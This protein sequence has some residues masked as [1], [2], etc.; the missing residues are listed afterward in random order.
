MTHEA[1]P[2][3]GPGAD[4]IAAS[5]RITSV[6]LLGLLSTGL[7]LWA[8][9][10]FRRT[11]ATDLAAFDRLGYGRRFAR[12]HQLNWACRAGSEICT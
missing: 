8:R 5:I 7:L 10:R 2:G 1:E 11:E 9:R 6:V 12:Y 4:D 3:S